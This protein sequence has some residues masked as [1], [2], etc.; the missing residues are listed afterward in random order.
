[1]E[2]ITTKE[3][4][5]RWGITP[6]RITILAS[7]G[8]IPGAYRLGKSWLIPASATKP[9]KFKPS[10][11][12]ANKI[13][14]DAFSFPLYHLRPDWNYINQTGLSMQQKRLLQAET[15]VLECRF[16]DAYAL[17]ESILKSPDDIVMEIGCLGIAGICCIALNKPEDFSKINLRLQMLLSDDFPH[18]D[19]LKIIFDFLKTYVETLEYSANGYTYNPTIHEQCVP[20]V[21]VLL[22][23]TGYAKE[24]V[25]PGSADIA[26]L[27]LIL[28]FLKNTG[29]IIAMQFMHCHLIAIYD[30]RQEIEKARNHAKVVVQI[31][32]EYK[33]YL[34][35]ATYYP[36][37]RQIFDSLLVDYP[38]EFQLNFQRIVLQHEE[39]F[40]TFLLSINEH[41]IFARL[42]NEDYP[43]THGIY[44]GLTN[45]D[46]AKKLGVSINTVSRR[47]DKICQKLGVKNKKELLE[48]LRNNM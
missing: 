39:N 18:R 22:G 6:T 33:F 46:I 1:M 11:T 20:L 13:E 38:E 7:E 5:A 45:T 25:K 15:A 30:M 27:E 35:L 3:A 8:R 14:P 48:Y 32:F 41:T 34:P 28:R 40:A 17:L 37:Y 12:G 21:C 16:S 47:V 23:F 42:S 19:D 2:Y 29:S 36:Y 24:S 44:M 9:P 31:A 10:R 26:I 4:S 43:Y